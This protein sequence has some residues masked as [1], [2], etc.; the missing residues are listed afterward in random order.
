MTSSDAAEEAQTATT[1]TDA[2]SAAEAEAG[3]VNA[4][5]EEGIENKTTEAVNNTTE[6][7]KINTVDEETTNQQ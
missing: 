2:P 1:T 3:V 6:A 4:A 7:D 5:S